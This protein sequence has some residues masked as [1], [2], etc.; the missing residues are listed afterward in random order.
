[1]KQ[2]R[3]LGLLFRPSLSSGL[4]AFVIAAA[5]LGWAD[6]SYIQHQHL[7]YDYLFGRYGLVTALEQA[8]DTYSAFKAALFKNPLTYNLAIVVIAIMV[9]SIVYTLLEGLRRTLEG[10]TSALAEIELATAASRKLVE[11]EIAVR[12]FLR[13]VSLGLWYLYWILFV[14]VMIPYCVVLSRTG[15]ERVSA[16]DLAGASPI[17]IAFIVLIIGMHAHVIF[18]RLATLRPRLFGGHDEVV[19]ILYG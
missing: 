13:M 17:A 15:V 9:G 6:W 7:F 19:T 8:P 3:L 4:L 18:A 14:S 16:A 10:T 1:M 5:I 11:E 2:L 12:L